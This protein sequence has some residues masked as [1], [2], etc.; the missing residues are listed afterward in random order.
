MKKTKLLFCLIAMAMIFLSRPLAADQDTKAVPEVKGEAPLVLSPH[1]ISEFRG[2]NEVEFI[3][4][5]MPGATAYHIV[6]AK[7]RRFKHIVHENSH[8]S[9]TSYIIGNLDLGTYFFRVSPADGG[10]QGRFSETLSLIVV[11]PPPVRVQTFAA[12]N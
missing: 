8:V 12:I 9:D 11:P 1:D 5:K 2:V 10:I 7:D 6:L 3:W 4:L